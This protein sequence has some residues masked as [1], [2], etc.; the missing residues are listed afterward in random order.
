MFQFRE[1]SHV[2]NKMNGV[3]EKEV[4]STQYRHNNDI[5]PT[6]TLSRRDN[7]EIDILLQ[8]I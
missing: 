2:A 7:I 5:L 1:I 8:N 6:F 4:C 3:Y